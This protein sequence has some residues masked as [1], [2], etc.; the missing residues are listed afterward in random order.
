MSENNFT[1]IVEA[2]E[3][4]KQVVK[5][6]RHL[7]LTGL[8]A[9]FLSRNAS[10]HANG[11]ATVTKELRG[12]SAQLSQEM[13]KLKTAVYE[14]V[15]HTAKYNSQKRLNSL[16]GKALKLSGAHCTLGKVSEKR[17][18]LHAK[19]ENEYQAIFRMRQLLIQQMQEIM[20][21]CM[22]GEQLSLHAKVEAVTVKV[23]SDVAL[24]QVATQIGENVDK[25]RGI[26][27]QGIG[28]LADDTE[29]F[30]TRRHVSESEQD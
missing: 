5:E 26:L 15:F 27:S 21:L 4:I 14:L 17:T 22:F 24:Q 3:H 19:G 7:Y 12:F 13:E 2:N 9:M 25:I 6:S 16:L 11:Y 8:N 10:H 18:Q 29:E 30:R 20:R 23:G 1:A 28:C